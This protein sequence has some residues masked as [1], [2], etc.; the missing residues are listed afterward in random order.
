VGDAGLAATGPV[1]EV[2][3]DKPRTMA[4]AAVPVLAGW[5]GD[6]QHL[7]SLCAHGEAALPKRFLR[8]KFLHLVQSIC[9]WTQQIKT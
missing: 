9:L 6:G 4:A 3:E 7:C 2:A 1:A 8:G 5:A